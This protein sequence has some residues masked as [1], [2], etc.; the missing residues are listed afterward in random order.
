VLHSKQKCQNLI[1]NKESNCIYSN[2]E[3]YRKDNI[4]RR[5]EGQWLYDKKG[6]VTATMCITYI[7]VHHNQNYYENYSVYVI[8]PIMQ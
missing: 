6:E 7:A 3:L 2:I 4:T 8:L 5:N 1:Q